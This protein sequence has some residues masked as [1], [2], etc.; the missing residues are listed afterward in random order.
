MC[1]VVAA[2][3]KGDEVFDLVVL[4]ILVSMVNEEMRCS[5]APFASILLKAAIVDWATAAL[6]DGI[7]WTDA[8]NSLSLARLD[9]T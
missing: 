1:F 4:P 2:P 5:T 7:G 3:T 6:P 8:E 9:L